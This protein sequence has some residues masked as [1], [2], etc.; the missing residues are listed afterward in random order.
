M[1]IFNEQD[2]K[3]NFL[4]GRLA[5]FKAGF[6]LA[7]QHYCD[8]PTDKVESEFNEDEQYAYCTICEKDLTEKYSNE[9]EAKYGEPQEESWYEDGPELAERLGH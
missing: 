9:L 8:H 6:D 4:K 3:V 5:G 1:N 7:F 2:L